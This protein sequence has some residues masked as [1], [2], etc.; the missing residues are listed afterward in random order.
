MHAHTDGAI[1]QKKKSVGRPRYTEIAREGLTQID[2][3]VRDTQTYS[4][5][6]R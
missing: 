1:L 4:K 6:D 5:I 3:L 2:W